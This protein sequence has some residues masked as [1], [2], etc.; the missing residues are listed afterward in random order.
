[1]SVDLWDKP[2]ELM[3][4]DADHFRCVGSNREA[5]AF[6]MTSWPTKGG[7]SFSVARRACLQALDGKMAT[8]KA[9][10]AFVHAAR[11][12]GILRG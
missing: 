11:E 12:A 10:L 4:D 9:K 5:V 1:M 8:A 2:I 7:K 6:L 3:M